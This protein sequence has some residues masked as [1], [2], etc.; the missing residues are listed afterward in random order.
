[1]VEKLNAKIVSFSLAIFSGIVYFLCALLFAITPDGT[2]N[3]FKEMFH[4]V[5]ITKIA[6]TGISLSSTIIGFIEIVIFS[7]IVGW[8]FAAVYNYMLNKFK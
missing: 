5:D 8:L 1:M 6:R 4:G 3:L 2:L 7:L